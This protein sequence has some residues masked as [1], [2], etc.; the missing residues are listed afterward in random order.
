MTINEQI[1][2]IANQLA[3]QGKKP[4]VALIKTQLTSPVPLPVIINILKTWRH[5]PD[6]VSDIVK[7]TESEKL[8]ETPLELMINN[9]IKEAITPLQQELAEL[10]AIIKTLKLQSDS[11]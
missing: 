2:N 11:Q 4:T 3:N 6:K 5:E 7:N 9:A 10:K 1:I 8:S